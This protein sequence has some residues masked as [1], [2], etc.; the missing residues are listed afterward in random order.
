LK[1]LENLAWKIAKFLS[2]RIPITRADDPRS[3]VVVRH[4]KSH[5]H[6]HILPTDVTSAD[7]NTACQNRKSSKIPKSCRYDLDSE[8]D[9]LWGELP[10]LFLSDDLRP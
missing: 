8:I 4:E 3:P 7:Y 2:S 10:K 9:L 1:A 6:M 5:G